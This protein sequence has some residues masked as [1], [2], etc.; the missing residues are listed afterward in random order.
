M[1][2]V[3]KGKKELMH[4]KF[5]RLGDLQKDNTSIIIID[6]ARGFYDICPLSSS[7]VE[8]IISPLV[9]LNEK[10]LSFKKVFFIDCHE[11]GSKEFTAYPPHCIEGTIESEL[12]EELKGYTKN[13][14]II[15]KDSTNRFHTE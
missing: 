5:I 1:D 10:A 2:K 14:K 12:I 3:L 4:V 13:N 6:M 8:N 15:K 7:R 9:Y 11:E